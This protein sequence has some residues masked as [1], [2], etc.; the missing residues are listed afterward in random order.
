MVQPSH[1]DRIALV[2]DW[3]SKDL[4]IGTLRHDCSYLLPCRSQL[5][6]IGISATTFGL[7]DDSSGVNFPIVVES[8]LTTTFDLFAYYQMPGKLA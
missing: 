8:F 2:P 4:K 3:G 5:T 6:K 7:L 1:T